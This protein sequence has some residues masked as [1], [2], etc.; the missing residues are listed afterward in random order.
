MNYKQLKIFAM[1]CMVF[2]HAVRIFPLHQIFAPLADL[3]WSGGYGGLAD[4]LL[5]ECTLYVMYIGRLAAPIFVYCIA[6]GFAHTSNVRR[7][8]GRV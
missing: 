8:I 6:Q 4:W 2:D 5:E 7:Y 1:V 3:L